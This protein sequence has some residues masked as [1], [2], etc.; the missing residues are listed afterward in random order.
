LSIE[1]ALLPKVEINKKI[2]I[3]KKLQIKI[4]IPKQLI[5]LEME[6][7]IISEKTYLVLQEKLQEISRMATGWLEYLQE[8]EPK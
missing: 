3:V 2:P 4:E 1:A 7:G 8:K 6:L 5:R